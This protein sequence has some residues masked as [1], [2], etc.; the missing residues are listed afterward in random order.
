MPASTGIQT[1]GGVLEQRD[2]RAI[3]DWLVGPRRGAHVAVRHPDARR[4]TAG[5]I[6][7]GVMF[8][9]P[10]LLGVDRIIPDF[11]KAGA[12]IITF[13]PEASEHVDRT[14]GL[15]RECGCKAGLVFNPATPLNYLEK[16]FQIPIWMAPIAVNSFLM[17]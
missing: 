4:L 3:I 15:I 17:R 5:L 12:N 8:P 1:T 10:E 16:I 13:H 2:L 7:A 6:D 14:I 9:D 11:A